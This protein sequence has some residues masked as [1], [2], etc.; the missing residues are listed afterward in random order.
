MKL[1]EKT[2]NDVFLS[3]LPLEK[4]PVPDFKKTKDSSSSTGDSV[5]PRVSVG[6][7]FSQMKNIPFDT[8]NSPSPLATFK[9]NY[10]ELV[11][12]CTARKIVS[13]HVISR[14]QCRDRS[15]TITQDTNSGAS[16]AVSCSRS[17]GA[18][19]TRDISVRGGRTGCVYCKLIIKRLDVYPSPQLGVTT[20]RML[21]YKRMQKHAE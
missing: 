9:S 2:L 15:K 19:E 12:M 20:E 4:L 7:R 16:T 18:G 5:S 1:T 3:P 17:K 14:M 21:I 6:G 8:N 10:E 13:D 11:E